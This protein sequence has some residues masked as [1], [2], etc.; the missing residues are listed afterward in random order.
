MQRLGLSAVDIESFQPIAALVKLGAYLS[1]SYWLLKTILLVG[2]N[3]T[4]VQP[5]AI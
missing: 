3:P 4:I 1:A 2:Q 5:E